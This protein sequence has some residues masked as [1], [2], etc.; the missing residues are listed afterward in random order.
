MDWFFFSYLYIS[1]HTHTHT[2]THTQENGGQYQRSVPCTWCI[3][4]ISAPPGFLQFIVNPRTG[5]IAC[6]RTHLLPP[7]DVSKGSDPIERMLSR[8]SDRIT[9]GAGFIYSTEGQRVWSCS[10][11]ITVWLVSPGPELTVR[12]GFGHWNIMAF[13]T[14]IP[15]MPQNYNLHFIW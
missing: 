11:A 9:E 2:H 5:R 12:A 14:V 15:Y 8:L 4:L 3:L 10:D 1:T 13:Y 6:P 7:M